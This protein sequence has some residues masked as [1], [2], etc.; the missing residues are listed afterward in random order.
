M[1]VTPK[2]I[3]IYQRPNG[4]APFVVWITKLK[5]VRGKQ[6]I[7]ARIERVR[8]GNFGDHRSVGDGVSELRLTIGPGYRIYYG[9]EG[10]T[11]VILLCAG[12][13]STQEKDIEAAKLYWHEYQEE[14]RNANL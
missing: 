11:V 5:D 2:A 9:Q 12:D 1:N 14:K 10:D 3:K 6:A 7:E 8:L 4:K 13:K